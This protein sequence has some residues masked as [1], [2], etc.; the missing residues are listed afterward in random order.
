MKVFEYIKGENERVTKFFGIPVMTQTYDSKTMEKQQKILGNFIITKKL[1]NEYTNRVSKE[2]KFLGK[3]II[4]YDEKDDYG[5]HYIFNREVSRQLLLNEFKKKYFKYFDKKHDDIYILTAN[6][7]ETYLILTY[8]IDVLLKRNKSKAPLLVATS[9]YHID[10]INMICPDIPYVYVGRI[11][12][13]FLKDSFNIDNF[14][15]Y[16]LLNFSHFREVEREVKLDNSGTYHYFYAILKRLNIDEK[17]ISMRP[18]N[19]SLTNENNM[20]EK[21]NNI[22]LNLDKF[23]FLAPEAQSCKLYDEDFWVKLI[24]DLQLKG[25]DVFVNLTKNDIKLAGAENYKTCNLSFSEAFALAR[26]AKRIVSL[27]SGL[28]ELLLQTNI[29]MDVLYTKFSNLRHLFEGIDSYHVMSGFGITRIPFVDKSKI[30]EFNMF[31][32][33]PKQCIDAICQ[34]VK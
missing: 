28:T 15:F 21:V 19:I 1:H 9:K 27:R 32:V 13:R 25:Y 2:T 30:H 3:N 8:I 29:P 24:N 10:L 33:S 23:V 5:I 31:E 16:L 26:R 34:A 6:S 18:V 14:K 7:G 20:L 4:K 22:G 17:E 12:M 11:R